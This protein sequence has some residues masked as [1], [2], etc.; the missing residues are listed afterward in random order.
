ML[1]E[2]MTLSGAEIEF[3][4]VMLESDLDAG[5]GEFSGP[6]WTAG[7][8]LATKKN[9]ERLLARL[10]KLKK[11]AKSAD[12]GKKRRLD[13]RIK[14]IQ[15]RLAAIKRKKGRQI[16]RRKKRGKEKE[17]TKRQQ[18]FV[19]ARKSRK[20]SVRSF[21]QKK[22]ISKVRSEALKYGWP[23]DLT[24][25][26][27]W[28]RGQKVKNTTIFTVLV[29]RAYTKTVKLMLGAEG[30]RRLLVRFP[31]AFAKALSTIKKSDYRSAVNIA[32]RP[33]MGTLADAANKYVA[34]KREPA[35]KTTDDGTP[36][37]PIRRVLP[38]PGVPAPAPV[39][40]TRPGL[41][42]QARLRALR[43]QRAQAAAAQIAAQRAAAARQA[44]LMRQQ[45]AAMAAQQQAQAAA[46]A[47]QRAAL[48]AQLAQQRAAYQQQIQQTAAQERVIQSGAF[49]A[50]PHSSPIGEDE[51][52]TS[53]DSELEMDEGGEDEG[54]DDE[55]FDDEGEGEGEDEDDEFGEAGEEKPFY[56]NP[57]VLLGAAAAAI[58]GYQQMQKKKKGK[59][60]PAKP[61]I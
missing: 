23:S 34:E 14:G 24:V 44:E 55:G 10:K 51:A 45:Q 49:Q 50:F 2:Y 59:K 18:K 60:K 6:W 19:A 35:Q 53:F 7:M 61:A 27:G 38:A 30:Q 25:D 1:E 9:Y 28:L 48:A 16:A 17:L 57:I 43:R 4:T 36:I 3:G 31:Q 58:Y 21:K 11:A 42:M 37:K 46:L 47:R 8:S 5:Y 54:F 12:G 33:Y 22:R 56:M 26:S 52:D 29:Y 40:R 41:S 15:R 20:K 13:R 39:Y 32:F